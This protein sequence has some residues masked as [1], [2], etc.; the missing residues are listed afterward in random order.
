RENARDLATIITAEQGK[1]F[2]E[3]LG[4]I[5]YGANFLD[6]FAS[7]GERSYGETIPSHLK[8]GSLSVQMQPIGVTVAITPWNFPSAMIT[9][10][11]GAA[12][13]AGCTMIVKPAPE[14]P[15]SALA[16]AKLAQ[17][18]GM[19]DGVFQVITGEAA[20]LAR[21]LLEHPDVRGFSFTGSTE[22]GR[23]LLTQSAATI[24]KASLELGGHA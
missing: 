17:E 18:A 23:I 14:T 12:L 16:L 8:G 20:P 10:K 1:P 19:P 22:V 5:S 9:R 13:A 15:L 7:E 21:H 11:A 3:S 2:A 24:K 4:E 6:W